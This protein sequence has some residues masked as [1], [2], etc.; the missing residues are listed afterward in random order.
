MLYF[1]FDE[2]GL[3][4]KD[5]QPRIPVFGVH[6]FTSTDSHGRKNINFLYHRRRKNGKRI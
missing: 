1:S 3:V 4:K 5:T 2:D 6:I